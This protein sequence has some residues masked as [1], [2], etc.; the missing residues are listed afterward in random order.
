MAVVK[1]E[2]FELEDFVLFDKLSP[3]YSAVGVV[4]DA[5]QHIVLLALAEKGLVKKDYDGTGDTVY[6]IRTETGQ[7]VYRQML[8]EIETIINRYFQR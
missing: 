4:R 7:N 8:V 3:I 2:R 6:Y 1:V 5:K